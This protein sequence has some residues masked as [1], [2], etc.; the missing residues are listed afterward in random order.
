LLLT[1]L[2]RN[3]A[4]SAN[5]WAGKASILPTFGLEFG[6]VSCA[7]LKHKTCGFDGTHYAPTVQA[8][9]EPKPVPPFDFFCLQKNRFA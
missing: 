5:A 2:L 6:P 3:I 4:T 7:D 9:N 1:L 8:K